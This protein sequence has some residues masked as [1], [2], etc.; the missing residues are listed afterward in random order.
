MVILSVNYA[1][2]NAYSGGKT[3]G[4]LKGGASGA[5]SGLCTGPL[6]EGDK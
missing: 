3:S 1:G 6:G 4:V 5:S 2:K